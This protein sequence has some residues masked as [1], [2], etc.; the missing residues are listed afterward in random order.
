MKTSLPP[1]G[2]TLGHYVSETPFDP[3]IVEH[4]TPEQERIYLA[5]QLKLM[6]WKFRRHKAAVI[7]GIFL[8]LIYAS[9]LISEFLAP[10]A[11]NTRHVE[12]IYMPPQ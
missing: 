3:S 10:Y 7:S 11:L 9:I 8:L 2:D 4:L 6:W 5:S 12:H 1:D